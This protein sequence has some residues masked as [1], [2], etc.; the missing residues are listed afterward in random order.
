[1]DRNQEGR[2]VYRGSAFPEEAFRA[3]RNVDGIDMSSELVEN[4]EKHQHDLGNAW[5]NGA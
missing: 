1:V 4:I 3:A 2:N 5:T